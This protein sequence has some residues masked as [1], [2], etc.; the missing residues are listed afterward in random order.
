[1]EFVQL[2]NDRAAPLCTKVCCV[3]EDYIKSHG[4][5]VSSTPL[6][7]KMVVYSINKDLF[8]KL[9][10]QDIIDRAS[11][12]FKTF[13]DEVSTECAG[14]FSV[15][16]RLEESARLGTVRMEMARCRVQLTPL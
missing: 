13:F 4:K 7:A 1:M 14:K 5:E 6:S 15:L 9:E 10:D 11:G 12:H 8:D 3:L 2:E 16:T